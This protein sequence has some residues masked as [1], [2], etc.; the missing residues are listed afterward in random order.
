MDDDGHT[1]FRPYHQLSSES[2]RESARSSARASSLANA[3]ARQGTAR[4]A[5]DL[6]LDAARQCVLATG[7][8]RATLAEIARTAKVSRMTLY[9]RFPDVRSVL[10]ALMTREFG[11]LLHRAS[12]EAASAGTA[13][14]RLVRSAVAAVHLL[15]GDDLVRTLIDVDT[16]LLL[17]YLVERLGGTQRVGEQLVLSY[18]EAGRAD[19]SIRDGELHVQARAVV[20]VVQSFVLSFRAATRDV[21]KSALLGQLAHHLDSA[22]R[23]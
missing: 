14:Q 9:R 6:L 16:E 11:A 19:G 15:N 23:P 3:R 20:L 8:R 5:D 18:L 13:R 22:L 4:V 1:A 7:L 17:P 2:R 12:A 10:S 21:E